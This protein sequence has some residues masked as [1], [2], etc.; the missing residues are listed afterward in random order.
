M[1]DAQREQLTA[2]LD[3]IYEGFTAGIA[4]SRGKTAQE[5]VQ[6]NQTLPQQSQPG[7]LTCAIC[8]SPFSEAC[9]SVFHACM[10]PAETC[11]RGAAFCAVMAR[12][13]HTDLFEQASVILIRPVFC[14]F[15]LQN[16]RTWMLM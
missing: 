14:I 9:A 6:P 5:V 3:D 7:I 16:R 4:A 10:A 2:I 12:M 11:C 8:T 15:E 1:S 13:T